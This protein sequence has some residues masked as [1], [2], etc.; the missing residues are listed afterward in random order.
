MT[1]PWH[2]NAFAKLKQM[3]DQNHLP[4]ALLITGM[5]RIGKFELMQQ[6]VGVLINNDKTIR[7]DNAQQELDTSV[8]IRRSNYLNMIYCRAGEIINPCL[9]CLIISW[10]N[11]NT[12]T[13]RDNRYR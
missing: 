11:M 2:Q 10:T 5:P 9:C 12:L 7:K 13:T 4:H 1:L 8:L 6:L 3:I